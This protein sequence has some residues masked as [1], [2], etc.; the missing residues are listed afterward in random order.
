MGEGGAAPDN[1]WAGF[2]ELAM[3]LSY[4]IVCNI[5]TLSAIP[6]CIIIV[7]ILDLMNDSSPGPIYWIPPKVTRHGADGTRTHSML[8]RQRSQSGYLTMNSVTLKDVLIL[9]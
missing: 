9:I 5:L 3:L 1:D 2:L 8:G 7:I 6:V 4:T